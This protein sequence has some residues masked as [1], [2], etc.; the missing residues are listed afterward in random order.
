VFSVPYAKVVDVTV[1]G[2]LFAD[3]GITWDNQRDFE[4]NRWLAGYG[5][6]LRVYSPFQDVVRIDVGFNHHDVIDP[7]TDVVIRP[8]GSAVFYFSTGN[9]F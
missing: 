4:R 1:S 9:R 8:A 6:G 7:L 2:V 5:L 3:G